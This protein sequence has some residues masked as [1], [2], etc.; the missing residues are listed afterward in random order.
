MYS[1]ISLIVFYP[2][3][4]DW[5]SGLVHTQISF[6]F[7]WSLNLV[8]NEKPI[9]CIYFITYPYINIIKSSIYHNILTYGRFRWWN[10]LRIECGSVARR[11]V[12]LIT[13]F[14]SHVNPSV[15]EL[16][17]VI[18]FSCFTF[19]TSV[20]FKLSYWRSL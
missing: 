10:G 12:N 20:A 16:L 7:M 13:F 14:S 15:E 4:C 6:V 2:W 3:Q 8:C 19:C 5:I 18:Y 17:A 9:L 1:L 11:A